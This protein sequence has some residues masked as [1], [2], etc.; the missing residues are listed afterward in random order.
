MASI[1]ANEYPEASGL[2]L[3]ALAAVGLGLFAVSL[4]IN[5]AARLIIWRFDASGGRGS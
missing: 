4:V 1:I 2:H 5:S 3:S